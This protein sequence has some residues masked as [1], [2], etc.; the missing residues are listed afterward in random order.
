MPSRPHRTGSLESNLGECFHR[1]AKEVCNNDA[2]RAGSDGPRKG[3]MNGPLAG[4]LGLSELTV[5]IHRGN[6]MRARPSRAASGDQSAEAAPPFRQ[7]T[8]RGAAFC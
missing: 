8:R 1:V 3:L 7:Q 4:E 2:A 5:R 6:V